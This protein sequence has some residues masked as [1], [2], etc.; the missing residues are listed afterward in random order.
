MRSPAWSI[1]FAAG[2]MSGSASAELAYDSYL[3]DVGESDG[4]VLHGNLTGGEVDNLVVFGDGGEDRDRRMAMYA[5]DGSD[6]DLAYA[7]EVPDDV[8]F[9]DM[10]ESADRDR[11]LMFRR[12]HVDWLNPDG[13]IRTTLVSAPSV[14]IVPPLDVPQVEIVRDVNDDGKG[15]LVLPDFDGRSR[16]RSPS[17]SPTRNWSVASPSLIS[18]TTAET[19]SSCG[20]RRPK[21]T[22]PTESASF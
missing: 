9:V 22:R 4:L 6:W 19:T 11:L 18:T 14:Y 20:S 10:L 5:F 2:V 17:I 15:D 1:A 8:I 16:P 7:A 13:W 3:I 21:R 12:D